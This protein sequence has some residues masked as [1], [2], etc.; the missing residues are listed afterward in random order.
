MCVCK[1]NCRSDGASGIVTYVLVQIH[2][3]QVDILISKNQV[4]RIL[5]H[6]RIIIIYRLM[7]RYYSINTNIPQIT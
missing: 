7:I 4:V 6:V 3:Y 1:H 2:E 5:Y